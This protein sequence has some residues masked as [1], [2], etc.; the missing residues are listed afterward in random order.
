M[1][2]Y[3][4][5]LKL[6]FHYLVMISFNKSVSIHFKFIENANSFLNVTNPFQVFR[7]VEGG[8]GVFCTLVHE[9][10]FLNDQILQIT[11]LMIS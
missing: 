5:N 10:E 6:Q 9:A 11:E 7:S 1:Y 2:K 3:S 4:K 8:G